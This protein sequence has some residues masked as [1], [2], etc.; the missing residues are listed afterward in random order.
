[1]NASRIAVLL[2]LAVAAVGVTGCALSKSP[3]SYYDGAD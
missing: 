2:F 3:G 1:M